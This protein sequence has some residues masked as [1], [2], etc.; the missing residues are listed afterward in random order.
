IDKNIQKIE[1][2]IE[3]KEISGTDQEKEVLK[4]LANIVCIDT[5]EI[6][7]NY[8][9]PIIEQLITNNKEK[10]IELAKSKTQDI[11]IPLNILNSNQ[12]IKI[13]SQQKIFNELNK[14][15]LEGEKISLPN[16]CSYDICKNLLDM[17][18]DLYDWENAEKRLNKK[19]SNTY[20]A[21]MM[22]QWISGF[23]LS[24]I[25]RQSLDYYSRT[26]R[27][28]KIDYRNYEPFKK[29]NVHHINIVI[30]DIIDDIEYVLRFLLEKYFNHYYQVLV[31]ILGEEKAG[32][33]W[34]TRLE[35]GTQNRVVIALQNLGL[36]RQTALSINNKSSDA[37]LIKDAKL[38]SIN[39]D[40]VLKHFSSNSI[41]YDEIIR[42]L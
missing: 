11:T 8:K 4:Y 37:L 6:T 35:Y 17:M 36:S 16:E 34:A 31:F 27:N 19:S 2:I 25:I 26:Q 40:I 29:G 23:N 9:S 1:K 14:K 5:L 18:Y 39:K 32:E 38:V 30:E 21:T 41:E 28:I 20:F 13:T 12:S 42:M 7:S 10:I 3:G 15:H 24:Q 33:N 22:N